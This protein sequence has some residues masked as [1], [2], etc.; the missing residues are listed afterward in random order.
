MTTKKPQR[1]TSFAF[2]PGTTLVGKYRVIEKL[3]SGWEAEVYRVR[4]ILTGVDRAAK[5][6]FPH[7]NVRDKAVKFYAKKLH[8]LRHCPIVIQYVTQER[9]TV[10]DQTVTFLVSE[11]AEGQV[12]T[13][14]LAQQ[15]QKRLTP[16]EALH[17]LHALARGMA[18][19][20]DQKE[21]HCD[22]HPGNVMVQRR[23]LGFDVKIIDFF[24]WKAARPEQLEDDVR[25]LVEILYTA[26]GG[27][28]HYAKQPEV[29]RHIVCGLKKS[30]LRRRFRS[31][32]ELR[33][34]LEELTWD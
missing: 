14:F 2:E 28:R 31:A 29:I 34:H 18:M 8:K 15:P 6:F 24:Q 21:S 13:T 12:L 25:G 23:G 20:H 9:M 5:F 30:L 4:E 19:I 3:G 11:Y 10:F 32:V 27:A 1:I 17:L 7:R 22:L 33:D 16:F 26:T